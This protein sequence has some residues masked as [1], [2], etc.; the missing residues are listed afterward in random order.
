MGLD[1]KKTFVTGAD[2]F[3]GSHLVAGLVAAGARVTALSLYNSFDS[4]GWLD[5]LAPEH[6]REIEIV[7]G[8]VRDAPQMS[9]LCRGKDVVFHLAALISVPF[10]YRAPA[11]FAETNVSGTVNVL[12]GARDAGVARFIH[13]STSEVYGTAQTL[14][15]TEDHPLRAQSPYAASKIGADM[16]AEAFGRTYGMSIVT[17]RPFNTYGPRQSERAV[18][19]ATVRQFLDPEVDA[20]ELGDLT[21]RRDFNFVGDTVAAFAAAAAAEL[22]EEDN[23]AAFNAGSGR[24]VTI[25]EM[26]D[27]VRAATGSNKPTAETAERRRPDASEVRALQAD[28]SKFAKLTGWAPATSLEDGIDRTVEWWR[29]RM[30][31]IRRTAAYVV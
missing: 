27:L 17:L 19:A 3:I 29:G 22:G 7:R 1:G 9:E 2:G 8:D 24:M 20:V 11:S 6:A 16:M 21:T 31:S 18:I 25:A 30:A 5:D 10:S 12:N 13:T 15:I 26:V 23:G 4:N 28:A 14:P